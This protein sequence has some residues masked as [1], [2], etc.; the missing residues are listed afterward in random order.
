MKNPK[1]QV[2]GNHYNDMAIQPVT[3]IMENGISYCQGN[4]IKYV[5]RYA[6]KNGIE[7][8]K[9]AKQYIDFMIKQ[10]EDETP[11]LG[12]CKEGE[13]HRDRIQREREAQIELANKI[14]DNDWRT[15]ERIKLP[16]SA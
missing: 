12:V 11:P 13:C 14:Y 5:C 1:T 16:L 2:G 3:F 10:V 15:K 4:V 9:K 8:L 6:D 7:D